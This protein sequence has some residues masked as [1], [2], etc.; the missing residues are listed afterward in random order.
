MSGGA[1]SFAV[2]PFR[3]ADEAAVSALWLEVFGEPQPRNAPPRVIEQ[4]RHVQPELFLVAEQGGEIVGT[5]LAGDDGHRG[6]LH[7]VAVSPAHQR[8]AVGAAL[9]REAVARLRARGVSKVNLQVR[10][11]NAGVVRFYEGLG[12][13]VEDR[14]SLGLCLDAD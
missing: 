3:D 9:V 11:D 6:W 13:E 14:I 4:K 12:F 8:G 1:T 10:G 7:L 2:R 5:T